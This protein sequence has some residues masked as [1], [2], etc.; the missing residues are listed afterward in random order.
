MKLFMLNKTWKTGI[1]AMLLVSSAACNQPTVQRDVFVQPIIPP[2]SGRGEDRHV[3]AGEWEY[4][5]GAVVTL[6]LDERGNGMYPWKEGRFETRSLIDHTWQ[7][8][9]F[10][11]ENDREGGFSVEFSHDF[12]EGEGRWWYTRIGIDLAPTQ[13]GGSF[14]LSRKNSPGGEADPTSG[15][16]AHPNPCCGGQK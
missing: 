9:W 3:L 13:K 8:M 4:E 10:Q 2:P 15:L 7:G 12:S 6:T 14:H 1:L 5:D 16:T 11:K